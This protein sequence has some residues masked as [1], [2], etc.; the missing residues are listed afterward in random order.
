[1][2]KNKFI[3]VKQSDMSCSIMIINV[4]H[5]EAVVRVVYTSMSRIAKCTIY[6]NSGVHYNLE[7]SYDDVYKKINE[8]LQ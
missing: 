2:I 7:D 4:D 3:E 5:I 1:M 8:V 6:C